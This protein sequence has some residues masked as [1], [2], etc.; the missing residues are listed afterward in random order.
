MEDRRKVW[1]LARVLAELSGQN[2]EVVFRRIKPRTESDLE[3]IYVLYEKCQGYSV[4]EL[5]EDPLFSEIFLNFKP[6]D[7]QLNFLTSYARQQTVLWTRQGGKTTSIGVKLFKRRVRRPG[8]QATITGPGLRQAKLVLE[9]LSDVLSKMDP[10]AYKAWVEKV[11]RTAI[12]LRNRSRL[13]AFPFSLE[14]LRGETSDDVDVEEAAFI[15]ECEELVQGTLTPQMA[16]RWGS[17]ASIILNSTPWGREFYYKTLHD[18][19]VSKFWTP[20][21]A[22]WRKAVE[23]GLITQEFI[24]LQRQQLDP[25][26]FA[27]EYE[28]KFTEDKG[29][30][31]SQELITACV[32]SS[33]VEP[34]RFEDTFD[35]LEFFMGLDVGQEVDNAALSVVEKV[36]ETRFL[37]YSHVFPLGTR[38]DVIASYV[39]VL[40]ERW[41]STVQIFV[42]STNERALA[43]AMKL[44]IY[45]VEGIAL[46]LQSKQKYASFLKQLMGK[47]QFRYYFDPDVIADLAIEQFEA[48]PGKSSEGEGNIRFFH[49]PG[50]HDDRFWSI[51]LA[52]AASIEVEPEPLLV[53]V[54]RRAN[55][56]QAIRKQLSKRKVMGSTR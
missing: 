23:A 51:C 8:S 40:S 35:G 5:G 19:N 22:D 44:Q 41:S 33:I 3:A 55:K 42:D 39:K 38:Y 16:T 4:Q 1:F 24:D 37:R 20:F 14:K 7:Y 32:D 17:G 43:E 48:L 34:W 10:I 31:L 36:G 56:L 53:V 6:T 45:G 11:L 26:R 28:N 52:V 21:V 29:R 25:D 54:P 15:K 46:S 50:T 2:V 13:K 30:W 9:K 27:R 12:R 47:K 18:P 49:A